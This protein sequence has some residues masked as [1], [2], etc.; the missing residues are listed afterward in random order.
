MALRKARRDAY[1]GQIRL[2]KSESTVTEVIVENNVD[3]FKYGYYDSYDKLVEDIEKINGKYNMYST[4]NPIKTNLDIPKNC[5][6]DKKTVSISD[7]DIE[8]RSILLIDLITTT[9]KDIKEIKHLAFEKAKEIS[10]CLLD[11]GWPEPIRVSSATG[12]YLL[13]D[14]DLPNNAES[15]KLIEKSLINLDTRFADDN[16]KVNRSKYNASEKC[17]LIGTRAVNQDVTPTYD[18]IIVSIATIPSKREIVTKNQLLKLAYNITKFEEEESNNIMIDVISNP[19]NCNIEKTQELTNTTRK[20]KEDQKESQAEIL[21]KLG[22]CNAEFFIDDIEESYATIIVNGHKETYKINS[23]NFKMS[24]IKKYYEKTGK[25]PNNESINQALG[26]F[27]A[28]AIFNGNKKNVFRR[29]AKVGDKYYYDLVNDDWEVIEIS[30]NGWRPVKDSRVVF[31]RNNNMKAQVSPEKYDDLSIINKHYR[32]KSKDDEIL[33]IVILVSS[34]TNIAHPIVLY[35]GEKGSSKSTSMKKDRAIVDPAINDVVSMPKGNEDLAVYLYKNYLSCIDNVDNVPSEK[36]D[37][38]CVASTGGSY[39]RRKMYTDD[40]ETIL[41]IKRPVILNGINIVATRPDLLDRSIL[42]E[43]ERVPA[44]ERKE[45][46]AIWKEFEEDKPKILGLIFTVLSK[47]LNIYEHVSL[48]RLGRMSDFTRLG[49]AIAEAAGI[50]GEVFLKAYLSNQNRANDEAIDLNPTAKAIQALMINENIWIGTVTELLLEL[51]KVADRENIDTN[52]K[53]W[54][55][56][57][58]VLSRRLNEIKSNLESVGISY[59]IRQHNIGKV[60]TI[61]KEKI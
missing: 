55:N 15:T 34:F 52:S 12:A 50:G 57:A 43:L 6:S 26:V 24:L 39:T 21:I 9:T 29:C 48:N 32:F 51:K 25:P 46:T 45:D 11:E 18:P 58:N 49:Y 38:L 37:L 47:A 41:Y 61:E 17:Q 3:G 28:K 5:F 60:I 33:H 53:L 56:E 7:D 36:S 2:I 30:R 44:E 59:V 35:H 54:A 22:S 40:D 10:Q 8:K 14:I 42:L 16:V 4:I 31:V 1:I 19:V 23:R 20:S 27:E 13:Y